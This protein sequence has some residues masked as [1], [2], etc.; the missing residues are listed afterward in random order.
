MK[1]NFNHNLTQS[2][3][4]IIDVRSQLE[5]QSQV[6][7]TIESG[8]IFDKINS[9]KISFDKTGEIN[10]SSYVKIPLRSSAILII[11]NIDNYCF[12][13]SISASLHACENDHP[14]RVKNYTQ[15][16]NELNIGG[17]DFTNGFKCS[18]VH[19]FN[20]I[21]NLSV[22][23]YEINFYQ[24]EDKRKH[25]LIPIEISKNESDSY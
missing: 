24:D 5:R 6:Q 23:I 8:W 3:I 10:G 25:N 15:Y 11:Q 16:F 18:D 22:K 19:R 2:D 14:S 1:N 13:W 4:D 20:E 7:E 17:F 9:M 12:F 21:N